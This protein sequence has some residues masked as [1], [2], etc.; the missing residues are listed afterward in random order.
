MLLIKSPRRGIKELEVAMEIREAKS[1][2]G[3]KGNEFKTWTVYFG[4][5][6]K[7]SLII[8]AC[9][10]VNPSGSTSSK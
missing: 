5:S 2:K 9:L 10:L 7:S 3:A 4:S 6:S 1:I 8:P